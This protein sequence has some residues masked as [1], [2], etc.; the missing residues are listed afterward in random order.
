MPPLSHKAHF[1]RL[2][3]ASPTQAPVS[4]PKNVA[5]S[6]KEWNAWQTEFG[7]VKLSQDTITVIHNIRLALDKSAKSLKVYVSDRRWQRAALL[8]KAS[9]YFC[10][11]EQTN[12]VDALLLRHCLWTTVDNRKKVV[13]IVEQ[14]VRDCGFELGLNLSA[15]DEEKDNL[16]KDINKE[17]FYSR[18]IYDTVKL[19]DRKQYFKCTK[20]YK[21]RSH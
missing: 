2:L 12:L 4:L 16:E 11:R 1:E 15:I 19:H 21:E 5:I 13:D 6:D 10:D 3:D 9:A 8:L 7:S 17:L 20:Q 14:A 18:D